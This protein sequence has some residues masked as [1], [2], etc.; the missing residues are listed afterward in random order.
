MWYS[1]MQ[2]LVVGLRLLCAQN[3]RALSVLCGPV[4]VPLFYSIFV[5]SFYPFD[6]NNVN[7]A[8]GKYIFVW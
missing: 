2:L 3:V 7:P 4:N 5:S 6:V 1:G 8:L